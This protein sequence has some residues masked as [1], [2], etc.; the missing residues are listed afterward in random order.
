MI[1]ASIVYVGLE[2]FWMPSVRRRVV[3]TFVLGLVHGFGFAGLLA[4]LGLPRGALALGLVSFNAGVE[5]GQGAF[6]LVALPVLLLLRRTL[7]W[8]RY[9]VPAGSIGIV[10]AGVWWLV[11]R[12]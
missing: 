5:L 2:N 6:V 9:G 10:L 12:S 4:E 3:V 8:P 11:E 1:A 7:W